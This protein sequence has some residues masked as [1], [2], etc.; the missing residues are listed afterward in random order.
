MSDV[1]VYLKLKSTTYFDLKINMDGVLHC[2][3]SNT[4]I[5]PI[6]DPLESVYYSYHQ[7]FEHGRKPTQRLIEESF[8]S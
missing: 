3:K 1:F 7:S 4:Y 8:K 6:Y 5:N 2:L